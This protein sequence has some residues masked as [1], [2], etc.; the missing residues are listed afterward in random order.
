MRTVSEDKALRKAELRARVKRALRK[1]LAMTS[2]EEH[3]DV[4]AVMNIRWGMQ[5]DLAALEALDPS[6][7]TWDVGELCWMAQCSPHNTAGA[8]LRGALALMEQARED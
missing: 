1:L 7:P 4:S 5:N 6:Q 8:M 3:W 2:S